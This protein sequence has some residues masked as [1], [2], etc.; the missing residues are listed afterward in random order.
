MYSKLFISQ[1]LVLIHKKEISCYELTQYFLAKI[2]ENNPTLNCF[3]TI[4]QEKALRQAKYLD[5]QLAKNKYKFATIDD[6]KHS[7]LIGIPIAYKDNIY[8]KNIP[9]TCACKLLQDFKPS[10][11]AK[12]VK[13]L[14]RAGC[15]MLGKNNMDELA[16]GVT[17]ETSYFGAVRNPWDLT[18]IPGGSSGGSA[19][20]VASGLAPVSLGTDTGGSSRQPSALCGVTGLKPTHGIISN[21]GIV[22]VAKSL[23]QIG[24]ICKNA[25]DISLVLPRCVKKSIKHSYILHENYSL[26]GLKIGIPKEC[27]HDFIENESI[28]KVKIY[29]NALDVLTRLGATI[30]YLELPMLKQAMSIYSI[31]SITEF[32]NHIQEYDNKTGKKAEHFPILHKYL[33]E[34]YLDNNN[35]GAEVIKRLRKGF[36]L[37]NNDITHIQLHQAQITQEKLKQEFAHAYQNVDVILTPTTPVDACLLGEQQSNS[38]HPINKSLADIYLC[39]ANLIGLPAIAFPIG[40]L[41]NMPMSLQLVG[42]FFDERLLLQIVH[43][44]QQA[45]MVKIL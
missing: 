5:K 7:G 45:T 19:C 9:T 6:I 27:L 13:N 32:L 20:A 31:L 33:D 12:I 3:I 30:V 44:Y 11:D 25:E 43:N 15:I 2:A 42:N 40:W 26:Q 10:F 22:P 21:N 18:K 8:T 35:I 39:P 14:T 23:D 1:L 34:Y 41:E 24:I 36:D 16:M 29:Q 28:A 17:N 37:Q 4:T 38:E